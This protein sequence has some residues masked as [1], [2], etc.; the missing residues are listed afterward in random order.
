MMGELIYTFA[1]LAARHVGEVTCIHGMRLLAETVHPSGVKITWIVSPES[2][3]LA[4]R[5]LTEWHNAYGD[6][7]AVSQPELSAGHLDFSGTLQEKTER[8]AA[9]RERIRKV[10]PWAE[11]TVAAGHTDPDIVKMCDALGMEGLWG[12]CWEQI[13]VDQ[14]TDRGCP[15]GVYYMHPD[16]RLRPAPGQSVV[17]MEWTSRDLLNSYHSGNPC[18]Y[19][20]D[21]NDAARGG[22]CSW[23]DIGYWK[24]LADNYLRNTRYNRHVFLLQHQEAHEMERNEGW[25]C[26][27]EEDIRE[28]AVML[29]EFVKHIQPHA[30]MMTLGEAARLYRATYASMPS[31]YMLW[32]YIPHSRPNPDYTWNT[33]PG[34]WPKTFLYCDRGA[35]M[36]FVDGRVQPVCIRNYARPW[37]TTAYYSEPVIPVVRLVHNTQYGWRREVEILVD[38]PSP[39]PYGVVFWGDYSLY[40]IGDAPGLVEGKILPRELLFLRYELNAGENRFQ[41]RLQGK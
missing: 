31:S 40:Q 19:S 5:E 12:F 18:L 1:S 17:A 15:W 36:M 14:I 33:S 6:D 2:A 26:Y 13:E 4:A 37:D 34:P 24:G 27:T 29:R 20:T 28:A 8:L 32:D 22:L 38:S 39:M 3:R 9:V 23:E 25:Y 35:Q 10:L 41:V 16:D 7:V 11:L 21:P 30:R